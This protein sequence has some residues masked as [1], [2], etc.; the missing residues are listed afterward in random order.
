MTY[1]QR[2]IALIRDAIRRFS[3]Q[4]AAAQYI[5]VSPS[6]I[7]EWLH[8]RNDPSADHLMKL[9]D[10]VKKAACVLIA[11]AGFAQAPDSGATSTPSEPSTFPIVRDN[12]TGNLTIYTLCN[13]LKRTILMLWRATG[14]NHVRVPVR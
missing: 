13:Y 2:R 4:R 14:P 9:Q 6:A 8:G 5:G 3:S 1:K 10:L 7:T 12:L 11:L